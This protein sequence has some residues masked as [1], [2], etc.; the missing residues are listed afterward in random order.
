MPNA[1]RDMVMTNQDSVPDFM[2]LTQAYLF[3]LCFTDTVF[4]RLKV[5]GNPALTKSTEAIFLTASAHFMS[6]YHNLVIQYFK[7]FH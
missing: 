6:L 5:C 3:L 4:Y 2:E 1:P 7:S